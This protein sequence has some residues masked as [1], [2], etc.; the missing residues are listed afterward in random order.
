MGT[1]I[2][3]AGSPSPSNVAPAAAPGVPNAACSL[4]SAA[5]STSPTVVGL[6]SRAFASLNDDF[7]GTQPPLSASLRS[8]HHGPPPSL[9]H[10][11]SVTYTKEQH[12]TCLSL[13]VVVVLLFR[14]RYSTMCTSTKRVCNPQSLGAL[15]EFVAACS[16]RGPQNCSTS[17]VSW[18]VWTNT[19]ACRRNNNGR[20][21]NL[22][23]LH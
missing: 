16:Q 10:A 19:G 2:R 17:R 11:K 23:E 15:R 13:V 1:F 14:T 3:T 6:G 7:E 22:Q 21:N 12:A 20:V 9:S 18:T 8:S 5:C 4:A